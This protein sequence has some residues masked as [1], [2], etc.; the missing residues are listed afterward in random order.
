[1]TKAKIN[2]IFVS[3][4]GEGKYV[5]QEQCFVRFY[6]CNLNCEFCDTK[7]STFEEF[8]ADELMAK[9]KEV[10]GQ[11]DIKS[12]SLTGG[13]PL[14]HRDFLLEFIPKLRAQGLESYLETNGILHNELFDVID[15]IDVIA[16][17]IK[18][19]SS[20]KERPFW[21][22]H[23]EFLKIAKN[24][25]T[26]IKTIICLN[27]T[28]DDFKNAVSLVLDVNPKATFILQLNTEELGR[29]LA[30]KLQ[31]FKKYGR[32]YLSDLRVIPQLHKIVGVK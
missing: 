31:A 8:T 6:G 3:I 15:Y 10:I 5:G 14:L 20:T 28:L 1:M 24:K 17:D 19:P 13:E 23:K 12:I 22:E 27:T 9:I 26:F 21:Q 25:D 16:M 4:Q 18:L 7:I 30:E 29:G 32:E 2:D 11:K